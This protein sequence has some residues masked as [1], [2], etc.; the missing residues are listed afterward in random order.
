MN[1]SNSLKPDYA[2]LLKE[3]NKIPATP[4]DWLKVNEAVYSPNYG[5][6]KI[7]AVLGQRVIID[8]KQSQEPVTMTDWR[9]AIEQKNLMN[10]TDV[11]QFDSSQ[12]VEQISQPIFKSFAQEIANK[13]LALEI[14]PAREGKLH[15][16]PTDL[17][18]HFLSALKQIGIKGLY[19]H[20]LEALNTLRTGKDVSIVTPTAS[21]KTW[22]F[23]IAV[24][25]S[26][27]TSD[28]TA[29]YIYPLKALALDQF[30]KLQ[31]LVNALPI[32]MQ[33]KVGLM[34]GDIPISERH[35][36]FNP[37]HPQI[38]GVSPDLLHYQLYA[39]RKPQEWQQW[40]EFLRRLRYCVVDESHTYL[41]SFGGH[42]T[43]LMRRLRLAV[44]SVGGDSN[45]L[46]FVF[47][48]ASIGNPTQMAL[49]FT[50]REDMPNRLHL[51][52]SSGANSAER[53]IVCLE[54]SHSANV[55]A[56][57]LILSLIEKE[58]SGICF[59]NSRSAIKS[60]LRLI[61]Q[62][63]K[64][65]KCSYLADKVAIFYGSLTP[66]RRQEIIQQLQQRK[67]RFILSTSALEAGLDLP[68][69]DCVLIRGFPGSIMSWKQRLG[70]A[71]RRNSGLVIFL[72][73]AQNYLDNYYS[74]NT[75]ELLHKEAE[76]AVFNPDYP[77]ILGKHLLAGAVESG[78]RANLVNKY[79]SEK[80]LC[81]ADA[82]IN[83]NQLWLGRNGQLWGRGYPHRE[84]NI[85]GSAATTIKLID[86]S[87]GEEFEEMAQEMAYREV[88]PNAIYT[89]QDSNSQII[90]Y[91]TT[92]LDTVNNQAI[93]SPIDS[94]T[95]NFTVAESSLDIRMLETLAE[96][97]TISVSIP[98]GKLQLTLGWGEITAS[99]TGYKL[100]DRK[101]QP[102]CVNYSCSNYRRPL[103][104][105]S[106]SV[107]GQR[108]KNIEF[109]TLVEGI[110][111]DQPYST[112]YN[113]PIVRVETNEDTNILLN[114]TVEQLKGKIRN[115]YESIPQELET[116]WSASSIA[117]ALHSIGHQMILALPLVILGSSLDINF[118]VASDEGK[119]IGYFYDAIPDGNGCS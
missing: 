67:I 88:F 51:I 79:F 60:L 73:I 7:V 52:D 25:E 106:C 61:K 82:L 27:L 83:Q 101:Y 53:T 21:G 100:C 9:I 93:L 57:S 48:S 44:D 77:V 43:N 20:Q 111:F 110:E 117:I 75:E 109:V 113:A 42:F 28:A 118:V 15:P 70:R 72:P 94:E 74:A 31:A 18:E 96:Q 116:L 30:G 17:P 10:A 47:S 102:S 115:T 22:C 26:C 54:P 80:A 14:I 68:E 34:T 63:A 64:N 105:H 58:V 90:K 104:G 39:I 4:P 13:I 38:L 78:I 103:T 19:S 16:L 55:D 92:E 11:P 62:S 87:T 97:K 32:N 66:L 8:F 2:A 81:I 86:S 119:I 12:Q 98:S 112:R 91:K 46:Q 1:E 37:I 45:S 69:L 89:S 76:S 3:A 24:L 56:A 107:C 114:T 71:G 36:L 41:G 59:V 29:L 23:N 108:L 40:R 50:G 35:L 65:K 33:V 84:I 49:H 85:R 6:G 95:T 99:V 5:W